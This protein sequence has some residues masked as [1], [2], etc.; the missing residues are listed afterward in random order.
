MVSGGNGIQTKIDAGVQFLILIS[1]FVN[2]S[3][4]G[5]N[6]YEPESLTV[7]SYSDDSQLY[8][9]EKIDYNLEPYSYSCSSPCLT[10]KAGICLSCEPDSGTPKFDSSSCPSCCIAACPIL[11]Y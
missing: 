5:I 8:K 6:Y 4:P 3:D 11:T 10:C 2:P 9:V 7:T 1:P